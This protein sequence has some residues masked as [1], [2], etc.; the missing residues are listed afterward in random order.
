MGL[1][2]AGGTEQEGVALLSRNDI[3][4]YVLGDGAVAAGGAFA[5][6][7]SFVKQT[8][9]VTAITAAQVKWLFVAPEF[10]DLALATVQIQ[11]PGKPDSTTVI[12]FDPPG[13]EP[14]RGSHPSLRKI[15]NVADESLF[16]NPNE[17]KDPII[18]TAFRLFTSGTTGS[19]KAAEISHATQLARIDHNFCPSPHVGRAL[20]IIGMYHISGLMPSCRACLGKSTLYVST[21]EDAATVLDRIQSLGI[22]SA[23]LPPRIMAAI[24]DII[25][26]GWRPLE[27]LQSLRFVTF[28]GALCRKEI[29]EAFTRFLPSHASL[30]CS[31]GS[32]ESGP[33]SAAACNTQWTI[34]N[35]GFPAPGVEVKYVTTPH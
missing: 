21:T 33:I 26:R 29:I 8:E 24:A 16:L 23:M 35:V 6:I 4:Y 32:T 5:G 19:V 20:Q 18:R 9:L 30:I 25:N 10:L 12:V 13:L 14:Y 34:G 17:G 2:A 27:T 1:N 15:M 11:G 28:G 22:T 3:Y 31:Y 7:P